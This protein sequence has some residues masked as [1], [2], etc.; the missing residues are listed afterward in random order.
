[1]GGRVTSLD[2]LHINKTHK[3]PLSLP[4][5]SYR[6]ELS[7]ADGP[8]VDLIYLVRLIALDGVTNDRRLRTSAR[9]EGPG[10]NEAG[11]S[12]RLQGGE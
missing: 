9:G 8:T 10:S 11:T 7:T 5:A 1:M 4:I 3:T 12:N 6:V 2:H